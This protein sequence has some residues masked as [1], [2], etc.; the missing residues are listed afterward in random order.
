MKKFLTM[1]L[2]VL[3]C[4][5]AMCL[6]DVLANP[7]AS[8][9]TTESG[10]NTIQ[11][12]VQEI[13]STVVNSENGAY[14]DEEVYL[15]A[16]LVWHEA[17]NQSY[18]GKVAIAEVLLNRVKSGL[19]PNSISEVI[20]QKGQ[21]ANSHRIKNVK[22]TEQELR[23]AYNVLNGNLRVLNDSDILYFRNPKVATGVSASVDKDWGSLDYATYIGDH[24]FYAQEIKQVA[25]ADNADATETKTSIFDRVV[26]SL[27]LNNVV[28]KVKDITSG[29]LANTNEQKA[30]EVGKTAKEEKK[31]DVVVEQK[32]DDQQ[33]VV[34]QE[35]T[36]NNSVVIEQPVESDEADQAALAL[37]LLMTGQIVDPE[38]ENADSDAIEV[39]VEDEETEEDASSEDEITEGETTEEESEDSIISKEE[40][41]IQLMLAAAAAKDEADELEDEEEIDENDPVARAQRQAR[42]DEKNRLKQMEKLEAENAKANEAAT[43][44]AKQNEK[45]AVERV[46]TLLKHGQTQA[47]N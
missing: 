23:I 6:T 36:E 25:D 2:A 8:S 15:A 24:A 11:K 46:N 1:L 33:E 16:Q 42:I 45:D 20:N 14:S 3:F 30:E 35:V 10:S 32:A 38:A 21:F 28:D 31:D 41:Q 18:N 27:K 37:Q 34:K 12:S 19:F 44:F 43:Q 13:N 4:T 9:G 47:T 5:T 29:K 7:I 40:L 26:S 17:H 39:I 22:P